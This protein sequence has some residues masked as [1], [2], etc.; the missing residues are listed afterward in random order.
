LERSKNSSNNNT[1]TLTVWVTASRAQLPIEGA[2]VAVT[3]A[4]PD[5]RTLLSLQVTDE[6]GWTSPITLE[7][8]PGGGMGLT[9]GGPIPFADYALWVEHPNYEVARIERFQIFPGVDSVQEVSLIPLS[10]PVWDGNSV[11]TTAGSEPQDL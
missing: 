5:N 6:S 2:T 4:G 3:T 10:R 1:G 7:S 8:A 9:P 11:N